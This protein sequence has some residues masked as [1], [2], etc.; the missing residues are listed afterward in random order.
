MAYLSS[1]AGNIAI[2]Q[3]IGIAFYFLLRPGEYTATAS[4]TTPFRLQDVQLFLGPMR[5]NVMTTP[6]HHLRLASFATLTFTTQ[7]NGI[8]GE[9]IGLGRSG[10]NQFCPVLLIVERV[11][12]L[13]HYNAPAETPLAT[14]YDTTG[15]SHNIS[16]KCISDILKLATRFLGPTFGLSPDD[17]SASS[18]RASGAMALLCAKVDSSTIRLI[19]RWRSNEMFRYLHTQAE[20]IMRGYAAKMLQ[21]GQYH[22]IPGPTTPS[23]FHVT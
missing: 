13:R 10:H 21:F 19:G 3:M 7:K 20:P 14:Y 23:P 11:I 12:H 8:A 16:P 18:L 1:I 22:L 5:L 2:A 9:V 15:K 17:I 4:D 6:I